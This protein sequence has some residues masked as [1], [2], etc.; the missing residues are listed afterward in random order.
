LERRQITG[1]SPLGENRK[2]CLLSQWFE[3]CKVD[4]F[5][6]LMDLKTG[7]KRL[8]LPN[9]LLISGNGRNVGKTYVA[10]EI[11]RTLSKSH[12]V[13]G[14]KIS[15]HFHPFNKDNV[16]VENKKFVLLEE[17]ERN[18]KDSSL[19]LQAGAEKVVFVMAE[20]KNLK[21]AFFHLNYLLSNNPIV[22]ESG[23]LAEFVDPGVFLF[24][25][26]ENDEIVKPHLLKYSPQI[27]ENGDSGFSLDIANIEFKNNHFSLK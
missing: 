4:R 14:V 19:M 18:Q 7:N 16:I 3:I 9:L 11:I 23:G 26:K 27:I 25:K 5:L 12:A 24:V 8:N 2:I 20:Q 22:C 21:E 15:S 13:T 10:C 6:F 17:K 1:L